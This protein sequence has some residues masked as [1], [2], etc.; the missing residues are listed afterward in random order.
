MRYPKLYVEKPKKPEKGKVVIEKDGKVIRFLEDN[1]EYEGEGKILYKV[2]YDDFPEYILMNELICDILLYYEFGGAKQITYLKKG[3]KLLEVLAEGYKV[4][5]IVDFGC[6][7]L[8]NHRLAAI[9]TRKGEIRFINTPV[10][11]IVVFLQEIPHKR[12]NY[13][14][15]ILPDKEIEC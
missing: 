9:Q 6:R 8:E 1:E 4:Y 13:K 15:Y 2:I 7:I 3:T 10:N 11:G 12:E 14:F 5:P